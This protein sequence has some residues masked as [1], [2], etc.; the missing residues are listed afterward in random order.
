M[1]ECFKCDHKSEDIMDF[2]KI[3]KTGEVEL[4][5]KKCFG[6]MTKKVIKEDY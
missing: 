3:N 2:I 6:S 1:F 4:E 5:C